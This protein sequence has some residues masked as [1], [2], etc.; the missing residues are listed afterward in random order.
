METNQPVEK[1]RKKTAYEVT[2]EWKK[3]NRE[4]YN[5]QARRYYVRTREARQSKITYKT[6]CKRLCMIDIY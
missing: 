3:A 6:E 5:E 4:L 2:K 1:P